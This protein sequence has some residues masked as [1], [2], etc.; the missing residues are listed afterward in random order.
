MNC[1]FY[2]PYL[3]KQVNLRNRLLLKRFLTAYIGSKVRVEIRKLYNAITLS[4]T[5]R[6]FKKKI[7]ILIMQKIIKSYNVRYEITTSTF[8]KFC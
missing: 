2:Y 4:K 1:H 3:H 5:C 7:N 6:H 8:R